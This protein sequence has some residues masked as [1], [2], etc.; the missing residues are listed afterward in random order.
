LPTFTA[1]FAVADTVAGVIPGAAGETGVAGTEAVATGA[2]AGTGAEV[3]AVTGVVALVP[4]R[5]VSVFMSG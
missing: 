4:G 2:D 1:G 5:V 3:G